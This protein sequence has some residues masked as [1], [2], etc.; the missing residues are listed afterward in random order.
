[1]FV[2]T[3]GPSGAMTRHAAA[4]RYLGLAQ[5][6]EGWKAEAARRDDPA[7]RRVRFVGID[8][9]SALVQQTEQL[10]GPVPSPVE[11]ETR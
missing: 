4:R 9:G 10:S 11:T 1:V 6:V 7:L 8:H 2:V 5:R 3:P